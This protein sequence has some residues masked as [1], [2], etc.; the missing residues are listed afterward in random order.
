MENPNLKTGDIEVVVEDLQIENPSKPLPFVI[1][2]KSVNEE[3]KLKYRFLDL[4]AE[5]SFDKFKMR[6]KA[7]IAARLG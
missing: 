5:G 3:T 2:D 4:R 7:A 6:S 1:G